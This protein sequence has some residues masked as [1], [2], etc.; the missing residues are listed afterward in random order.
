MATYFERAWKDDTNR[1]IPD[2]STVLRLSS[3]TVWAWKAFLKGEVGGATLG[4]WTC[5]SSSSGAA[6][7]V[8]NGDGVD[9]LGPTFD[10]TKWIR[11]AAGVAHTW[12]VLT[13]TFTVNGV[14]TPM[15]VTFD[16]VGAND[17]QCFVMVWSKTAPTGGTILNR[18]T[19]TTD[20]VHSMM[21]LGD[22]T[23]RDS[24]THTWLSANGD[25]ILGSSY[26]GRL[27]IRCGVMFHNYQPTRP[28]LDQV[29]FCS[30]TKFYDTNTGSCFDASH[31][32][33]FNWRMRSH[34]NTTTLVSVF[35]MYPFTSAIA[36]N[37]MNSIPLG[38]DVMDGKHIDFPIF[39]FPVDSGNVSFR[40]RLVDITWASNVLPQGSGEPNPGPPVSVILGNIW[41]PGTQVLVF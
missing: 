41:V 14:P 13:H 27:Q 25:F 40:G 33:V 36:N 23:P 38:G 22:V 8:G 26:N 20:V 34:T 29:P 24:K 37:P 5:Y 28:T 30:Y 35:G 6:G 18:P 19:S 21:E 3:S 12:I 1:P 11:A 4:L 9:R 17:Y 7:D 16:L 32:G 10:Y 15:Y 31:V 2:Y 39:M